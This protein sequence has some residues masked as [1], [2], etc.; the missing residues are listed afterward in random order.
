MLI[1]VSNEKFI[2]ISLIIFDNYQAPSTLI[3]Y[4]IVILID[5]HQF[6][7]LSNHFSNS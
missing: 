4:K 2:I 1:M 7:T 6:K 5:H 3:L